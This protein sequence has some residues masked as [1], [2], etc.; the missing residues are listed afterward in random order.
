M[1]PSSL[2]LF[3]IG[4]TFKIGASLESF[5][6]SPL[7]LLL[8]LVRTFDGAEFLDSLGTARA[9]EV[10]VVQDLDASIFWPPH[11]EFQDQLRSSYIAS[12]V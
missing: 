3:F 9:R 1:P 8:S 5:G 6:A 11:F 4:T 10:L 7:S 2:R 12:L